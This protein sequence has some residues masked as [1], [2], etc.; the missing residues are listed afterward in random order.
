MSVLVFLL[1]IAAQPGFF[2]KG[3]DAP[4]LGH[5]AER[6]QITTTGIMIL[7]SSCNDIKTNA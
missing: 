4:V 1:L 5:C 3:K 6:M 7:I 2:L